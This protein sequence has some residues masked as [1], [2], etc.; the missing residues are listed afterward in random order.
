MFEVHVQFSQNSLENNCA[1]VS[2]VTKLQG[3]AFI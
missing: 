3:W 1:S 2:Y